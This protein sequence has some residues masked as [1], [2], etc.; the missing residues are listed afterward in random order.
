MKFA[1][2]LYFKY[3]EGSWL[4]HVDLDGYTK[5]VETLS[6]ATNLIGWL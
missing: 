2:T 5:H 3:L 4:F 1:E 6:T